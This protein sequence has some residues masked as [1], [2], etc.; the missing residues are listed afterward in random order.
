MKSP[1]EAST[2]TFW[3]TT[4]GQRVSYSFKISFYLDEIWNYYLSYTIF[5]YNFIYM[6]D[7][8]FWLKQTNFLLLSIH[9]QAYM[10]RAHMYIHTHLHL[11]ILSFLDNTTNIYLEFISRDTRICTN[12]CLSKYVCVC[13]YVSVYACGSVCVCV[14][15]SVYT[16]K[17]KFDESFI[18]NKFLEFYANCGMMKIW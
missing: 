8:L 6:A 7:C 18:W 2:L 12:V 13:L 17:F 16:H 15:L 5:L 11:F 10:Q 4:M 3:S 1:E 14:S 9:P